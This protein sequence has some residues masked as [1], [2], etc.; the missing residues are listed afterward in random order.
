MKHQALLI[1]SSRKYQLPI[2]YLY[3]MGQ[4]ELA[5]W[6]NLP[7][8][9]FLVFVELLY[10]HSGGRSPPIPW[11]HPWAFVSCWS[12]I[13]G[14]FE[15]LIINEKLNAIQKCSH[16]HPSPRPFR[17]RPAPGRRRSIRLVLRIPKRQQE[18]KAEAGGAGS[19]VIDFYLHGFLLFWSRT[20]LITT[21]VLEISKRQGVS[22]SNC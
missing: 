17:T 12:K 20:V 8:L 7:Q 14:G 19:R 10:E 13:S 11:V 21:D 6:S 15:S 5:W 16:K 18:K 22:T 1:N 3:T 4:L 2:Y 9:L